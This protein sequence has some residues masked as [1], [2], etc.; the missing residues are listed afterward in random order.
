[1]SR[2]SL[3]FTLNEYDVLM[4][5]LHYSKNHEYIPIAFS[6]FFILFLEHYIDINVV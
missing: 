4:S 1:M 6:Y 5:H 3:Y 2:H